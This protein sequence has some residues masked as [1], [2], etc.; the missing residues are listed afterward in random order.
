[1]GNTLTNEVLIQVP[2]IGSAVQFYEEQLGFAVTEEA[3]DDAG[4]LEMA[5][6]FGD[7]MNLYIVQGDPTGAV[8][9]VLV[10][11]VDAARDRILAKGG[12]VFRWDDGGNFI[13]DPFGM[14][15]HLRVFGS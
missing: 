12:K 9:E 2:D 8:L 15:Y 4:N 13:R 5:S 6:L 1:M 10:D 14:I 11:D 7:Y 3:S